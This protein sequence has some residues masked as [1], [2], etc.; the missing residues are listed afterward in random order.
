MAYI[1]Y[2]VAT[3]L[4]CSKTYVDRIKA[5]D[6][7]IEAM[8]LRMAESVGG[9]NPDVSEYHLDDGQVKVKTMYRSISEVQDGIKSLEQMREMYKNKLYGRCTVLRNEKNLRR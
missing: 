2:T 5:I 8:F 1:E 3:Y 9:M 4:E 7:L 6:V